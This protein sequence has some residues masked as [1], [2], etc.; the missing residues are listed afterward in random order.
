MDADLTRIIGRILRDIQVELTDEFDQNFEREG[1]F[2]Q[3][4]QRRVSPVR[5]DGHILVATGSLRRSIKSVVSADSIT[6]EST[7]PYAAIHN[8]GGE[9][10]VTEKMKRYFWAKYYEATGRF[11]RRKDGSPSRGK[12]TQQLSTIAEFWKM[13]ALM[14]VGK[15]IRIPRR[16]FMGYGPEVEKMVREIVEDNI[17]EYLEYEITATLNPNNK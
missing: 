4:W 17:Q 6:F 12:R 8:D 7:L 11:G 3:A 13:M 5:G 14:K 1:Y 9:I 16:K 10:T 2:A 15:K